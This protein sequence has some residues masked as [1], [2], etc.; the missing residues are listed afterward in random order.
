MPPTRFALVLAVSS[1][2]SAGC[3]ASSAELDNLKRRVSTLEKRVRTLEGGAP[4][5]RG[6][7]AKAKN[8]AKSKQKPPEPMVTP[9]EDRGGV[10]VEGDA[11]KVFFK[12]PRRRWPVPGVIPAGEY[13]ILATFAEDQAATAAGTATVKSDTKTRVKCDAAMARCTAE[14]LYEQ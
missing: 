13:E 6:A 3:G 7:K 11:V 8:K 9:S 12:G 4:A 14:V 5:G 1:L 10:E 2:L